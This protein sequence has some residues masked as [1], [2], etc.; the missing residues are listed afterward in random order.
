MNI[1]DEKILD[2]LRSFNEKITRQYFYGYC[3]QA[4]NVFDHKYQLSS[5]TGLDFF[6]LAHEYYLSLIK[7]NFAQLTDRPAKASLASWMIGGFKFIVL[8]ALKAFNKEFSATSGKAFTTD[9]LDYLQANDYDHMLMKQIVTAV[10]AH[11][12]NSMMTDIANDIFYKGFKQ[13]EVSKK[14]GITASAVNQRYK[15]MMDEVVI[16]F[17]ME[18]YSHGFPMPVSCICCNLADYT[19]KRILPDVR[20]ITPDIITTLKANEI[21][22]FGSNLMGL[23]AGG[24]SY[25]A[26]RHFGAEWGNGVGLQGQSYAIPTMVGSTDAISPYVKQFTDFAQKHPELHFM[27]TAIGCG[28]AGFSADD[29]APLFEKAS[30]LSNVWLPKPFWDSLY[31]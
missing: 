18:N 11:Y 6:S 23:H 10:K 29:I 17:V 4:Y 25:T 15:K 16:P 22:V 14:L 7:N 2:G 12:R 28:L 13:N 27:V 20:N 1:S 31:A 3:K 9:M 21:F 26:L 24:A 5:K 19:P 30:L 8:D